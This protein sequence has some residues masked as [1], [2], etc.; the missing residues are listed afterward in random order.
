MRFLIVEAKFEN[1]ARSLRIPHA[2]ESTCEL[3]WILIF[4]S[5]WNYCS[6]FQLEL[7][8]SLWIKINPR[9]TYV[10][11][12]KFLISKNKLKKKSI[13]FNNRNMMHYFSSSTCDEW[14]RFVVYFFLTSLTLWWR[15]NLHWNITQRWCH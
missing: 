12:K 11:H 15:I 13:L 3:G 4:K 1:C 2:C 7:C 8:W 10:E 14:E 9:K 5:N 6:N